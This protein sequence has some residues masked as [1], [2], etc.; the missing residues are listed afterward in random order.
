MQTKQYTTYFNEEKDRYMKAYVQVD[1]VGNFTAD[2]IQHCHHMISHL[3][4]KLNL[5]ITGSL[6]RREDTHTGIL[7][8]GQG[9]RKDYVRSR[10]SNLA[11]FIE[12]LVVQIETYSQAT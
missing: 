12:N 5:C 2:E 7:T 6:S 11:E 9:N 3:A 10:S 1:Y 4:S 8:F